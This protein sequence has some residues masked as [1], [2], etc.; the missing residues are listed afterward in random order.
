MNTDHN[1]V[2]QGLIWGAIGGFMFHIY[3]LISVGH[4]A[5]GM[6]VSAGKQNQNFR[7]ILFFLSG[8]VGAAAGFLVFVWFLSDL[9]AAMIPKAKVCVIAVVAGLSGESLLRTL[10]RLSGI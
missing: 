6:A 10:R 2:F 8:A 3:W 4:A 9:Q 1:I 5:K 7:L